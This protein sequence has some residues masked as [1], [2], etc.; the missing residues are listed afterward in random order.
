MGNKLLEGK[1]MLITGSSSGIGLATAK[2]A[3]K[4]GAKVIPHG[5]SRAK[6]TE[7]SKAVGDAPNILVD[8]ARPD[9]AEAIIG[10]A[11][12]MHGRIDVLVNNAAIFPRTDIRSSDGTAFDRIF[13]INTRAPLLLSREVIR[14]ME[15]GGRGGSIV[16]IGSV[17]AYCGQPDLLVYSMSKGALM[18]MTRNMADFCAPLGVRINQLNVGWTL[19]ETEIETQRALGRPDDWQSTVPKLFAP[20]GKI[21]SPEEVA[22]HVIFWASAR[23]GPITGQIYDVELYPFLG[24]NVMSRVI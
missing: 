17:N 18:T 10:E 21:L 13:A 2:E 23:S 8:L 16:N 6:L 11:M 14:I 24:R 7:A 1:V 19:T 5:S 15:T 9:C 20:H 3:V 4:Y 22:E 12:T